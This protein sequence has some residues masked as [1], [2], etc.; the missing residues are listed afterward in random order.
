MKKETIRK[1]CVLIAIVVGILA[2]D[3]VTKYV[4]DATL[5]DETKSIIP[6]LFNFKLVHN[7]GAAWGMLAG[8]Q[9]FLIVLSIV[10][11]AIFLIYYIKEKNKTWFLSVTFGF[12]IAGCLGN[13]FDRVVFGYVRDFIQFD[14][15]K[16]FP[17]FNF[18]DVA[19][20]FGVIMFLIYLIIYFTKQSKKQ[21]IEENKNGD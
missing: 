5:G 3:L 18:A 16:T 6:G 20:V 15:W 17:V 9:I 4:L 21:K 10:F 8:K 7:Y 14:F 11:L 12:L 19:L 1:I 13:L 2:L